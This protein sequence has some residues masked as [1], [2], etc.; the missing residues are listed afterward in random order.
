MPSARLPL[1]QQHLL[2]DHTGHGPGVGRLLMLLVD[3]DKA[4]DKT[5]Y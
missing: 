5:R 1:L 4:V 3:G 2:S